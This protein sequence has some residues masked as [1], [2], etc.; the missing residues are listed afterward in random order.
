M[1]AK[2]RST[3]LFATV[4]IVSLPV[5]QS[6]AQPTVGQG[7]GAINLEFWYGNLFGQCTNRN[8]GGY[9]NLLTWPGGWWD[10]S[11]RDPVERRVFANYRGFVIGAR[12]VADPQ[13]PGTV[14]PYMVGQRDGRNDGE[15]GESIL[16]AAPDV[17]TPN[18][19]VQFLFKGRLARRT[20]RQARATV[21]VDGTVNPFL[22]HRSTTNQTVEWVGDED[23]A[24]YQDDTFDPTIPADLT[25]ETYTWTRM[26]VSNSRMIYQFADR[27]NDDYM[28]WHWRLINDGRWGRLGLDTHECC[29]GTIDTVQGVMLNFMVQWG[30]NSAGAHR[31]GGAGEAN[32]DSIWRYYGV[33]Y[34]GAQSEDMR[35]VYVIDG[36]Q[37]QSKYNPAH[38]KQND[39]GDPDPITGHLLSAKTGGWQILHYDRSPTDQRDDTAQPRTVGWENYSR[40][41]QTGVDGHEAKY[42]QML[43]G[44][45]R[46]GRYNLG[47]YQ[48]TSGR[49]PHP[50][51]AAGASWIKASNDPATSGQYWPGKVLGVDI[52]VTDIE[53]QVAFGPDDIAPFDTLNGIYVYAVKGLD[54]PYAV[55][56]GKQWLAGEI[57]D[58]HKDSLVHSTIDSLFMTMRQAKSVYEAAQFDDGQSGQRSASSRA[59]FEESLWAAIG[60]GK[61]ALSPPAPA[62]F[63]VNNGTN[64][65]ELSWT[66]NTTTGSDVA[67]WRVY[68][69]EGSCK[70]DSAWS[71]I[72]DAPSAQLAYV[73]TTALSGVDYFYYLTT[74]DSDGHE[75]TMH[76]RTNAPVAGTFVRVFDSRSPSRFALSQ[77][78][79]NPFNPATTIPFII[80]D[81]GSVS[82]TI[83]SVTGQHV[84]SLIDAHMGSGEHTVTWDGTDDAGRAVA[85]GVYL[86]RLS[87]GK[88]IHVRRLVVVR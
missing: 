51:A 5:S 4:C 32:N 17:I 33:D 48:E 80:P 73:D 70:G 25:F 8:Y 45:Q 10:A 43:W 54:E 14:W 56:V 29:G 24:V 60:Q 71:V 83:H 11:T 58:A 74:Y 15:Q 27:R 23:D 6:I 7:W 16:A 22:R 85:S 86:Y 66:L 19:Y 38:G 69:A 18:N 1:N 76:T 77:N 44:T 41:V 13:Y 53:Q 57:D 30:R 40:L 9:H 21:Q 49:D 84:R 88:Q 31:T 81:D 65:I 20:Y 26:G 68:R 2:L 52:D 82:L 36:D 62:T 87:A 67:G 34:D 50:E 37:S 46:D 63:D 12:N 75:S 39:I 42:N 47:P 55:E 3:L 35:L 59:E 28:F 61:L 64:G 78:A 79:P 72:L